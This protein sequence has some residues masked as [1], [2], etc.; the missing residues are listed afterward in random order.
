[1]P[2]EWKPASAS[3]GLAHPGLLEF[4]DAE[5][6]AEYVEAIAS[7]ALLRRKAEKA[8]EYIRILVGVTGQTEHDYVNPTRRREPGSM[9]GARSLKLRW[10]KGK[11]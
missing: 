7:L 3:D 1:L 2:T 9:N 6:G 5:P 11:Q 8:M 10:F 4:L